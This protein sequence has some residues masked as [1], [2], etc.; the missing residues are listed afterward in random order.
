MESFDA[1]VVGLGAHGSATAAELARRGH[2]VL[3]LERF[4][5]GETFGSAGGWSR[6]IRIAH[7]EH[8]WLV[9]LA[10]AAWD[11]WLALEAETGAELVTRTGGLYGGP[12][13]GAVVSGAIE[14]AGGHGLD[15]EL[16]DASEI[17]RRWPIFEPADD[18]V[19]VVEE[20]AGMVRIDRAIETHLAIAE[21]AGARLAFGRRVVDWRPAAGGGFEVETADGQVV[22]G[23]RISS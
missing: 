13:G 10:T 9:P 11:R 14:S 22:G 5:R 7:F 19:A 3:G 4:A 15:H 1:I 16:L 12:G 20:R 8:P 23:E 17:H 2:R 6:L 21:R 18:A